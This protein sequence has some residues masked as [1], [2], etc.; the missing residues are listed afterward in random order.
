MKP[1][2]NSRIFF[3]E[4]TQS[5][6][7][8]P[9]SKISL[10][11]PGG[12]TESRLHVLVVS[13]GN[14]HLECKAGKQIFKA[15]GKGG[16][17]SGEKLILERQSPGSREWKVVARSFQIHLGKVLEDS[18]PGYPRIVHRKE[19]VS[20][21]IETFVSKEKSEIHPQEILKVLDS[22]F[23]PMEWKWDHLLFQWSWKDSHAQ[24]Y[25]IQNREEFA[26]IL[27][28][29]SFLTGF[30]RFLLIWNQ[31]TDIWNIYASVRDRNFYEKLLQDSSELR[32][33]LLQIIPGLSVFEVEWAVSSYRLESGSRLA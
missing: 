16:F 14:L 26:F 3:S 28:Y 8:A 13:S 9:P 25:L 10:M 22:L 31:N 27:E 17:F 11:A 29:D 1:V 6:T 23:F 7:E 24:G 30:C 12:S 4:R 21:I 5:R 20:E 15:E 32:K 19:S 33:S 18:S 2:Q